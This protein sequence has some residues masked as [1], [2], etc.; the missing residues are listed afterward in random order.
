MPIAY[1]FNA[2]GNILKTLV[3]NQDGLI[4]FSSQRKIHVQ[5]ETGEPLFLLGKDW[6]I[7]EI[8][9][10]N[11]ELYI[12]TVAGNLAK[13]NIK[14]KDFSCL[15]RDGAW[16]SVSRMVSVGPNLVIF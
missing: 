3:Y 10:I 13:K 1:D 12:L 7:K 15:L 16:S 9:V 4:V 11:D 8:A 6:N 14:T 5:K 2:H